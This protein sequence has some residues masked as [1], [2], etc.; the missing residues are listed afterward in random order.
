MHLTAHVLKLLKKFDEREVARNP[1]HCFSRKYFVMKE[2]NLKI[3]DELEML[4]FLD[5]R[6]RKL[7]KVLFL[8]SLGMA[9]IL[10]ARGIHLFPL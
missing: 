10:L 1:G 5:R 8:T 4:R 7:T 9:A 6:E 3:I 2:E